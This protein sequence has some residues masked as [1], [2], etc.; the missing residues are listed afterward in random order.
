[1]TGK[2]NS[3]YRDICEADS[4]LSRNMVTHTDM[5]DARGHIRAALDVIRPMIT[6]PLSSV[7]TSE[8]SALV[9][10]GMPVADY[11][12]ETQARNI[13]NSGEGPC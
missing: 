5:M 1:M 8:L 4:I 2:L 13:G 9:E 11:I 6:R 12:A 3:A 7:P 10:Q